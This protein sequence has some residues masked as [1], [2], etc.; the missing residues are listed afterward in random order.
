[1][2]RF[3]FAFTFIV[4]LFTVK[5][6]LILNRVYPESEDLLPFTVLFYIILM[7]LMLTIC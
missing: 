3:P 7:T 4:T 5:F 2:F 1:M 6:Q